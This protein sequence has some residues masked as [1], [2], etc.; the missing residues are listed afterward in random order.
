MVLKWGQSNQSIPIGSNYFLLQGAQT[1]E[2]VLK[3]TADLCQYNHYSHTFTNT[4]FGSIVISESG[5]GKHGFFNGKT[6]YLFI[7]EM[8]HILFVN[9]QLICY[10][11]I[12]DKR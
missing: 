11:F 5:L 7:I 4:I 2:N 8:F 10:K 6:Y 3:N 9:F 1:I 12:K